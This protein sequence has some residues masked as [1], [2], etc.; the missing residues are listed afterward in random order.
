MKTKLTLTTEQMKTQ[1]LKEAISY[2]CGMLTIYINNQ[3]ERVDGRKVQY[4]DSPEM[5]KLLTS[6]GYECKTLTYQSPFNN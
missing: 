6:Q 4:S 2:G 5:R 3:P 1:I